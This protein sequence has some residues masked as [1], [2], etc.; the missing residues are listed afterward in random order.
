[1][2]K[3]LKIFEDFGISECNKKH[4][5]PYPNVTKST[6]FFYKKKDNGRSPFAVLHVGNTRIRSDKKKD[7]GR[8]PFVHLQDFLLGDTS[9]SKTH[10]RYVY[11]IFTR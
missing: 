3:K 11:M 5:T 7:N 6:N 10:V 8:D 4:K 9:D 2:C 1:M